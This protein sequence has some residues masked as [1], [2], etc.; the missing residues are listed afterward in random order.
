MFLLNLFPLPF[1]IYP[2]KGEIL[3]FP[4]VDIHPWHYLCVTSRFT[5]KLK[6][7]LIRQN[8]HLRAPKTYT[9]INFFWNP[10][11]IWKIL[12][13]NFERLIF[14]ADIFRNRKI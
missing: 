1:I 3:Y 5:M 4:L 7:L 8:A 14:L 2:L 9:A 11:L 13:S 6:N 12:P 10:P